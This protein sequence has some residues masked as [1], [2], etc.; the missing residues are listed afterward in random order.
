MNT[1]LIHKTTQHHAQIHNTRFTTSQPN[2]QI[3]NTRFTNTTSQCPNPQYK[4]H[5]TLHEPIRNFSILANSLC[6]NKIKEMFMVWTPTLFQANRKDICCRAPLISL[7]TLTISKLR[8]WVNTPLICPRLSNKAFPISI[9][10]KTLSHS[11]LQTCLLQI[12]YIW[13]SRNMEED[14]WDNS[15]FELVG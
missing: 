3:H 13:L 6:K 1:I 8:E 5:N 12:F 11:L 10:A 15:H 4:I 9:L 7:Q 14:T 2:V